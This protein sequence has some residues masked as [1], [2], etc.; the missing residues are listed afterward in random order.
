MQFDQIREDLIKKS[1][2][3]LKDSKQAIYLIHRNELKKAQKLLENIKKR[4]ISIKKQIKSSPKLDFLGAYSAAIQ[5]F[6]EARCYL[7][8][9][10]DKKIPS[11]QNMGV[12][13]EDYLLGLCD[14]TGEL[15]RRAVASVIKKD[16][17]EVYFIKNLVE[18]IYGLFLKLNLRNGELRRKSDSI[19]WNLKKI[20][21]IIYDMKIRELE[22]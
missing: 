1:R 12:Q 18:E 22:K 15:G 19:K 6:V 3:I 11:W 7:S 8:F 13:V 17:N 20:E 2:D 16:F 14:L 9:A 5:E 10:M 4:N 21:D